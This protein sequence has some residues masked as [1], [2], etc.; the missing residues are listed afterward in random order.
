MKVTQL[1]HELLTLRDRLHKDRFHWT[2]LHQHKAGVF[3]EIA[4]TKTAHV[5]KEAPGWQSLKTPHCL[6]SCNCQK[7]WCH[8]HATASQTAVRRR[9]LL[10][11]TAHDNNDGQQI[12]VAV[13]RI[14]KMVNLK[15]K[16]PS[17]LRRKLISFTKL[18]SGSYSPRICIRRRLWAIAPSSSNKSDEICD[19]KYCPF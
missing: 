15:K 7:R 5:W 10:I 16:I 18:N 19:L 2:A 1:K 17:S 14:Q 13:T 6:A 12:C 11:T 9:W 8:W 4:Q 3:T